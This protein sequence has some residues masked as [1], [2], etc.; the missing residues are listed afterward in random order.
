[1]NKRNTHSPEYKVK[2]VLELLKEEQTLSQI[3]QKYEIHSNLLARWKQEFLENAVEIFKRGKT[4]ADKKLSDEMQKT[5]ELE[6]LVG[7]LTYEVDWL[8][9]KSEQFGLSTRKA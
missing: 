1:M 6:K 3:A 9:K 8:K 4:E 5:Q 2:A 7:R